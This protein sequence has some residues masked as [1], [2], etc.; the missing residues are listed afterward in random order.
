MTLISSISRQL[1]P[2]KIMSSLD[3]PSSL[4]LV[5]AKD[6]VDIV[7]RTTMAYKEGGKHSKESGA[8]EARERFIEEV[9]TTI[10]WLGG[11]PACRKLFDLSAKFIPGLKDVIPDVSLNRV[12]NGNSV[13]GYAH[14]LSD[15]AIKT[16]LEFT[17][18]KE[19]HSLETIKNVI[20]QNKLAEF[21]E[22]GKK[23]LKNPEAT[24]EEALKTGLKVLDKAKYSKFHISK[25]IFSV[26][27]PFLLL[28]VA[29][30]KINQGLTKNLIEKKKAKE[31]NNQP[32]NLAAKPLNHGVD[33]AFSN[34]SV[35]NQILDKYS[36]KQVAFG[37][38]GSAMLKAAAAA[39]LNPVDNMVAVDL[40]ISGSRVI[41]AR[42]LDEKAEVAI[43]EGGIIFFF[44]FA[45]KMIKNALNGIAEKAF[46]TPINIDF[47]LLEDKEII[48]SVKNA[49]KTG[50]KSLTDNEEDLIKLVD[51]QLKDGFKDGKFN[52]LTL[53]AA[54][55]LGLIK[56]IKHGKEF[57]RDPSHFIEIDQIKNLSD[58]IAKFVKNAAKTNEIESLLK[59]T[60]FIKGSM[61]ILNMALCS[62]SLGYLLPKIQYLF[63]EMRTGS[64]VSPGIKA[65]GDTPQLI[66]PNKKLQSFS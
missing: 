40:G 1:T 24:A 3:N 4:F 15:E 9:G 18:G 66:Q 52:D 38:I 34:K 13:Q 43:R 26:A 11:I 41:N 8:H 31:P 6:S 53:E 35:F 58:D 59:K 55:K 61:T 62:I 12:I 54:R 57:M 51:K 5:G 45:S 48:Q 14:D 47:N 64:S 27:I 37:G 65:Y 44:F 39:Q 19:N 50:F 2:T 56:I 28:G 33:V 46:K 49:A 22:L 36:K 32:Q 23:A 60:K 17:K 25:V 20:P 42:N 29:L 16:A 30:P 7:G 63:R 21:T 10:I